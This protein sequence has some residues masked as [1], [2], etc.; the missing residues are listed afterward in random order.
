MNKLN[1]IIKILKEKDCFLEN[2]LFENEVNN[3]LLFICE[4]NPAC[5]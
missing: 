5:N 1:E 3:F 4:V 2:N